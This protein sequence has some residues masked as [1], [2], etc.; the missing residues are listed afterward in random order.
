M[1]DKFWVVGGEYTDTSFSEI[2]GGGA[3]TRE[4]P[5]ESIEAARLAWSG[6][7]MAQV[8]NAHARYRIECDG[9]EAYWVIGG[10]YT[11]TDF[12]TIID[13]LNE[14]RFGP[15]DSRGEAMDVWRGKAWSTVDEGYVRYRIEEI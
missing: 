13:G 5:F 2:V 6:L 8:D 3:E 9:A 12:T 4:G 10:T 7:S 14:E 11:D 1:A 15:Y